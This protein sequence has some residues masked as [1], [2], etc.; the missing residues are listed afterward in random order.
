MTNRY[1]CPL[2]EVMGYLPGR[3]VA[4]S[5][6]SWLGVMDSSMVSVLMV[7]MRRSCAWSCLGAMVCVVDLVPC[8]ILCMW[9]SAVSIFGDR[10]R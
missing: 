10:Y 5:A 9:P 2:A 4:R 8:L 6:L 3:S 7:C 1:L